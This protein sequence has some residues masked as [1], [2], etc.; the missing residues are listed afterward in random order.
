MYLIVN[1]LVSIV[2]VAVYAYFIDPGHPS[3][4]YEEFAK[5]SA[6]YSSVFAG[7]PLMFVWCWWLSRKWDLKSIIAIWIVYAI[8]DITVLSISGWTARLAVF[9]AVSLLTK[10]A[11]AVLGA[12]VGAPKETV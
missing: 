11:A 10:L 6:P 8:I 7:M 12:R 9:A 3:E 5:F 4:F 2:V 1:V